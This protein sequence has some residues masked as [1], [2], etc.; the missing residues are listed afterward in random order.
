[1][2]KAEIL[3]RLTKMKVGNS[4]TINL[5]RLFLKEKGEKDEL[6]FKDFLFHIQKIYPQIDCSELFSNSTMIGE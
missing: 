2:K 5:L 1:M 4:Y 3:A 6:S